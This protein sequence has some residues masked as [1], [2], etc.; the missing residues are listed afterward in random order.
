M[1]RSPPHPN[2]LGHNEP[3]AGFMGEGASKRIS[4]NLFVA[5]SQKYQW[6]KISNAERVIYKVAISNNFM[7]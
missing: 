2:N 3:T 1:K 4:S 7:T 6:I 5:T